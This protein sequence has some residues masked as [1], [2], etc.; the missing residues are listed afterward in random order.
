MDRE[1]NVTNLSF[2]EDLYEAYLRVC[3]PAGVDPEWR[4]YFQAYEPERSAGYRPLEGCPE[5]LQGC[6]FADDNGRVI[7][8]ASCRLWCAHTQLGSRLHPQGPEILLRIQR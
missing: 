3:D 1:F 8:A 2:V 4:A 6:G 7:A 5:H